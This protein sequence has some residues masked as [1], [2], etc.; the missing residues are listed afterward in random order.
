MKVKIRNLIELILQVV[1]LI[2][3]FIPGFYYLEEW[4]DDYLYIPNLDHYTYVQTLDNRDSFSL[5]D[6]LFNT[7]NVI[8]IIG[9]AL[10]TSIVFGT[11]LYI[12]QF[13]AKS[14]KRNWMPTVIVS[15]I[16]IILFIACSLL[17]EIND[18]TDVITPKSDFE[19]CY[20]I[21]YQYSLQIMFIVMLC[22][23]IALMAISFIGYI[24]AAKK[25]II[26]ETPKMY[27]AEIVK[28]V[29]DADEL[30][31]FKELLDSGIITQ[32]EF[33]AKKKQLLGL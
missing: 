20:G 15:G 11:V 25:G 6:S 19:V 10:C 26:E 3:V 28:N 33:D 16:E 14:N 8:M 27:K 17:I 21:E 7:D 4:V 29:S 30:Q 5:F 23:L 18:W 22:A 31:K 1:V 13:V 24:I 12:L 32:E 9:I 2:L